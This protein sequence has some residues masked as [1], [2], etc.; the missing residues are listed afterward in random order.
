M[1]W[2]TWRQFRTQTWITVAALALLGALLVITGRS[3]ADAYADAGVAGC[4]SDCATAINGFL[5]QVKAGNSGAVYDV[6]RQI[7]Y[8]LPAVIGIFWGAPL[9][10]RELETGTHRLAWNQSVT[11]T[12]WLATKLALV[13]GAAAAAAGLFSL[14][15]TAWASRIDAAAVDRTTPA[16]FGARGIV[17]VGYALLAFML[18]VTAGMLIRRTVPAM[19]AALSIYLAAAWSIANWVRVEL[20]PVRHTTMAF[21]INMVDNIGLSRDDGS[22]SISSRVPPGNGWILSHEIVTPT[23]ETFTGGPDGTRYCGARAEL[24]ACEEWIG[25]LNLRQ[26]ITHHPDSHFWPLQWTE[27]GIL[28]GAA[29]LMAGFCFW[30][31]RRRL[32]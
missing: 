22:M 2:F 3:I 1:I 6:A 8:G 4:G 10:A 5:Q 19:G 31:V 18:G 12:R 9:I 14:A 15:V 11:R 13:G 28:V 26:A 30:W 25:S 32:A 7:M 27:V 21:D 17:P 29:L 24:G 23:G 16:V 20:V